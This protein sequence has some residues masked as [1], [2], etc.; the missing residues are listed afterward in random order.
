M[1]EL[2]AQKGTAA[3]ALEFAILTAARTG[4]VL[5]A[6]WGEIKLPE[7]LWTVPKER[8]KAGK[9]HRVPLSARA[10]AI[11]E[12]MHAS[13]PAAGP[14][15]FIFPGTKR[16]RPLAHTTFLNILKRMGRSNLT[17]A[18]GFRAT[19]KTWASEET[20]FPRDVIERALAHAIGDK[21]EQAYE[22][23]D[24]FA[25]RR[26]LMR[27][28]ASYCAGEAGGNVTKLKEVAYG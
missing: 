23:G 22:R 11:L 24:F 14:D 5:G 12:I 10:A 26:D 7:R 1:S 8:M 17:T 6:T 21:T 3:L 20:N 25:K 4:E 28:W 27:A 19:F 9:P 18:H 2:R 13:N 15:S 16:Q